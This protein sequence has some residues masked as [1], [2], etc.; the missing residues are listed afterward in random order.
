MINL[1]LVGRDTTIGGEFLII[2]T[3]KIYRHLFEFFLDTL[4]AYHEYKD[5]IIIIELNNHDQHWNICYSILKLNAYLKIGTLGKDVIT[6][7]APVS[8]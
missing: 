7:L 5:F 2:H 6:Y 1:K 3:F 8:T 4:H